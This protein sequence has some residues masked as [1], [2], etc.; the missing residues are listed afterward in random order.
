LLACGDFGGSG[1]TEPVGGDD[2]D[3]EESEPEPGWVRSHVKKPLDK[4]SLKIKAFPGKFGGWIGL[5]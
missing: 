3:D 1:G 4:T 2:G 5:L